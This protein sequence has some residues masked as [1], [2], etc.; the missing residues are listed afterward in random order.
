MRVAALLCLSTATVTAVTK[1]VELPTTKKLLLD[2]YF[3]GR[4][5]MQVLDVSDAFT[6]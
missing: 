6:P 1:I 3:L 2:K 4:D 5:I